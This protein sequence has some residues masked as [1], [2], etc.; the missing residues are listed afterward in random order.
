LIAQHGT[1]DPAGYNRTMGG[2]GTLG[3]RRSPTEAE[4]ENIRAKL[5]GRKL[6]EEHKQAIADGM[7]AIMTD[8]RRTA[9]AS[10]HTGRKRSE[11]TKPR[12]ERDSAEL[13]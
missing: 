12:C 7:R 1:L 13:G 4:R 9:V 3:N 8:E 6:T 5:T 11:T 2:E 10:F